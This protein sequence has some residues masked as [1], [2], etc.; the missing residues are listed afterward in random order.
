MA[1]K[2]PIAPKPNV[3]EL[4]V[5]KKCNIIVAYTWN[6][7]EKKMKRLINTG[8]SVDDLCNS[9]VQYCNAYASVQINRPE[10]KKAFDSS[11]FFCKSFQN[12]AGEFVF[13]IGYDCKP[14][15][16]DVKVKFQMNP[17][18]CRRCGCTDSD[19]RDCIQRTGEPCSWVEHD[20]CSACTKPIAL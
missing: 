11:K 13:M 17:G 18:I 12:H 2:N 5:E 1:F 9:L 3:S 20:L 8:I 7:G 10:N 6:E 4:K 15:L 19:C 16:Y 14:R